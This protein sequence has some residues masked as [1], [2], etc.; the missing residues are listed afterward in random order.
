MRFLLVDRVL[1]VEPGT[2]IVGTK[3]VAMAEDYLTWH[4][5]ERPILPG[6]LIVASAAQLAGWLEAVTSDFRNTVLL[7]ELTHAR[8]LRFSVPGDRVT[9]ELDVE[10][11]GD[12]RSWRV[13]ASVDEERR[14]EF[15]C[16]GSV[17]PLAD[18][19]DPEQAR[20]DFALLR[21]EEV[22]A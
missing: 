2:R 17:V 6:N 5:P 8:F 10:A 7:G 4:F 12:R 9:I 20:R 21:G 22:G 15:E 13:K 1:E 19:M 18:L 11:E 3:L 14:A 16:A